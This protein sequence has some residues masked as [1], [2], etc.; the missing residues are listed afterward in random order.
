MIDLTPFGPG[1]GV[2]A[3]EALDAAC[4]TTNKNTVPNEP[5]SPF[6]P[7][8]IRLGTPAL[9]TRGMREDEMRKIGA[10]ISKV[11]KSVKDYELPQGK[12]ERS[13]CLAKFREELKGEKVIEEVSG[14]VLEICKEFPL[15]PGL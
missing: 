5:S 1:K 15:Y 2:F 8:G 4:I 9:T 14:A 12:A 7:S 10:L 6:Y 13:E 3:Q 11:I